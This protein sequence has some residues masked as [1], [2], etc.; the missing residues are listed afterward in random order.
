MNKIREVLCIIV[1]IFILTVTI[2]TASSESAYKE[3]KD[4]KIEKIDEDI[5]EISRTKSSDAT[6]SVII[7]L[8]EQP[9]NDVSINVKKDYRQKF[10]EISKPA[11]QIYTRIKSSKDS[12]LYLKTQPISE[13]KN[14]ENSLL[15]EEEK[16]VLKEVKKN[17]DL[18]RREMRREILDRTSPQVDKIQKPLVAKI[19]SQGGSVRYSSKIYNALVA[20]VSISSLDDLSKEE[21]IYFIYADNSLTASLDISTQAMGANISWWSNNLNGYAMD[22]AIIDTGISKNHPDLVVDYAG[23]FHREGFGTLLYHDNQLREDDLEGHGTHVAGILASTDSNYRGVGYGLD[24]LIN[25]KAGW[26]GYDN[27]G[28]MYLSDGMEAINWSIFG[29]ADDADVITFSFSRPPNRYSVFEHFLDAISYNLDI[30]VV[31]SAGNSGPGSNTVGEPANAFNIIAVGNINENNT[32]D[33]TDDFINSNSSRGPSYD[34]RIKPDISAPGT[35]IMSTNNKWET[36]EQFVSRSGTSMAAPHIAGGVL[37]ILD[38]MNTRWQPEAIK[39]LL[40]NTAEDKGSAGPDNSYGYGY[41]DMSN[42][43]LHRDDVFNGTVNNFPDGSVEKFYRGSVSQGDRATLVWNRHVLYNNIGP[44][45]PYS[46]LYASDLNLFMYNETNGFQISSSI[47]GVNNIEQVISNANHSSIILKVEPYGTYPSGI[48]SEDY[49]LATEK[50][51]NEVTPPILDVNVS[52]PASANATNYFDLEVNV[53]NKGGI[54]AHNV[55]VNITLPSG[56]S[57]VSGTNP[58]SLGSINNGSSNTALWVLRARVDTSSSYTLN[59]SATSLSYDESFSAS[60]NNTISVYG[61]GYVNGTVRCN[62]TEIHDALVKT[63]SGDTTITN[64]T[65]FYS[66][67]VAPAFNNLTVIHEPEHYPNSTIMIFAIS[68][69]TIFQDIELMEKPTGTINGEVRNI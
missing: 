69:N 14:N 30:P 35:D 55:S 66:I 2:I 17:V 33:R 32:P 62:G 13:I 39:A 48:T 37:L 7:V 4:I 29:N 50:G 12:E 61:D 57:I 49:A 43:Y 46:D 11:K 21:Y 6:I 59:V 47:S 56:F 68:G 28:H 67:R 8:K 45:D 9:A 36:E 5:K 51:F 23:V 40:L 19:T 16:A 10:E 18:K 65:G 63:D 22:A 25:A 58:L 42:A 15:T 26:L 27:T 44:Y 60:G 20:D 31:V 24:K 52:V 41:V 1:V 53:T 34:E 54:S 64:S 38:Y 3:N